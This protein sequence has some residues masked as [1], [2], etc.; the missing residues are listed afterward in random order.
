MLAYI[1]IDYIVFFFLLEKNQKSI[2]FYCIYSL[3]SMS[4]FRL[5]EY[6]EKPVP[7]KVR[8]SAVA[9]VIHL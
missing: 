2:L 8:P 7:N 4:N 6:D 1:V 5:L 9:T 3:F